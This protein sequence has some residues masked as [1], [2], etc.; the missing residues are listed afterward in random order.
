MYIFFGGVIHLQTTN[1]AFRTVLTMF[2]A[3]SRSDHLVLFELVSC[4]GQTGKHHLKQRVNG[5]VEG[6][7]YRKLGNQ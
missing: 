7:I 1:G 2:D 3:S 4:V 6:K 5:L